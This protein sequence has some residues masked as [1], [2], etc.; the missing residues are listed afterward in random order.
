MKLTA[1]AAAL[2]LV[3]PVIA[4]TAQTAL[5]TC[6]TGLVTVPGEAAT[7]AEG[8]KLFTLVCVDFYH[9]EHS[10][11]PEISNN[12]FIGACINCPTPFKSAGSAFGGCLITAS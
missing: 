9:C 7:L 1:L 12:D 5:L 10:V 6:N 2:P 3:I 11:A 8:A 4:G